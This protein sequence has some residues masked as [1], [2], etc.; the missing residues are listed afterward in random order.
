M[1]TTN[2]NTSANASK[3]AAA[4]IKQAATQSTG[5]DKTTVDYESFLKLLTAQLRNQDPLAPMDATQFMT[6]LAQLSTVEQGM[7][8]NQTM[9]EMLEVLKSNGM[10]MDMA[11][12]G[13]KVEVS[14]DTL[15]LSGGKSQIAY[16]VEG[17]PATVQI[18]VLDSAGQTVYS[19]NGS[20]QSGRQVFTWDGHRSDGGTAADGTYRVR[21]TAKDKAGTA[22]K[23]A[24]VVTDTVK[25]VRSADGATQLVLTGGATV[26][27]TDVLSAS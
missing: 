3:N 7:K 11:F 20:L 2:T 5:S 10:R 23:T 8:T 4:A 21:I 15:S 24:T 22:L 6:Q 9:G 18:D 19:A 27:S 12:L 1:T 26:N 14:S 17:A 16:A 25:E 13:R